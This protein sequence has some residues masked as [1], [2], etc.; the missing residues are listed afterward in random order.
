MG[1]SLAPFNERIEKRQYL[2]ELACIGVQFKKNAQYTWNRK[3]DAGADGGLRLS[4]PLRQRDMFKTRGNISNFELIKY[5][6]HR[7]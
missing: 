3:I 7:Y 1:R 4:F 2:I 5:L 6:P